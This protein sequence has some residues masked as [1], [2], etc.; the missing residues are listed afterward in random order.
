MHYR[1]FMFLIVA[2][3]LPGPFQDKAL[4]QPKVLPII[5]HDYR[6]SI[7]K[8][9]SL[10]DYTDKVVQLTIERMGYKADFKIFIG[11][12]SLRMLVNP[13]YF[14]SYPWIKTPEREADF[15]YSRLPIHQFRS[16]T[17][18]HKLSALAEVK[19]ANLHKKTTCDTKGS[20]I[21]QSL[22]L[23]VSIYT[24]STPETCIKMLKK[25]RIDFLFYPE[26]MLSELDL[27]F[28]V[29]PD[30]I[31][32]TIAGYF[33]VNRKFAGAKDL[34]DAFNK[35]YA[36]LDKEGVLKVLARQYDGVHSTL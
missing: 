35:A 6:S 33:I 11:N 31:H 27:E 13:E 19:R 30:D 26:R 36:E 10:Y 15:L 17:V 8:F 34:L 2:I 14:A 29:V 16:V 12:R 18:V 25:Q 21:V 9:Q 32:L 3:S 4:S 1:N 5:R 24:S 22:N 7:P 23:P 28:K 20:V